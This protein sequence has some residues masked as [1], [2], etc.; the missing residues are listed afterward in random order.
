MYIFSATYKSRH[1]LIR[2][3]NTILHKESIDSC[4]SQSPSLRWLMLNLFAYY[5]NA[6]SFIAS[7]FKETIKIFPFDSTRA[8]SRVQRTNQNLIV[9]SICGERG[10]NRTHWKYNRR[11]A[12]GAWSF[13][14]F[15]SI[16]RRIQGASERS[17]IGLLVSPL[18][19]NLVATSK[20][21]GYDECDFT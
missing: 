17:P 8:Y 5:F 13:E 18:T 6:R 4:L 9:R 19:S 1:P 20:R 16:L 10:L 2:I 12:R 21:A 15:E 14:F 11:I 3:K 7:Y